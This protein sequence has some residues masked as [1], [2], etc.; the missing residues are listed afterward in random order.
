MCHASAAIDGKLDK[1]SLSFP[2]LKMKMETSLKMLYNHDT[3]SR[4]S[5]PTLVHAEMKIKTQTMSGNTSLKLTLSS[6]VREKFLPGLNVYDLPVGIPSSPCSSTASSPNQSSKL[7][8]TECLPVAIGNISCTKTDNIVESVPHIEDK[9][10]DNLLERIDKMKSNIIMLQKSTKDIISS[11]H[12]PRQQPRKQFVVVA[13]SG[14][15]HS[16]REMLR[17]RLRSAFTSFFT[18]TNFHSP[19][20]TEKSLIYTLS[21]QSTINIPWNAETEE[22]LRFL[23]KL[24]QEYDKARGAILPSHLRKRERVS[25]ES[26][27]TALLCSDLSSQTLCQAW[28]RSLSFTKPVRNPVD[29]VV[30]WL[31]FTE[32]LAL[33]WGVGTQQQTAQARHTGQVSSI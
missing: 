15:S 4:K 32:F 14:L 11:H 21:S 2:N 27:A 13:T 24:V 9:T 28:D 23:W 5:C 6:P 20:R 33:L 19:L 8:S 3:I 30:G 25:Y 12:A 29:F 1:S 18:K 31:S 10:S 16:A 17:I 22:I 7:I 26:V